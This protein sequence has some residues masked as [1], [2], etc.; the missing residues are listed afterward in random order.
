MQCWKLSPNYN[1]TRWPCHLQDTAWHCVFTRRGQ[2]QHRNKNEVLSYNMGAY[3]H[4]AVT[5]KTSFVVR[6]TSA[7][8]G[9]SNFVLLCPPPILLARLSKSGA[10]SRRGPTPYT[11]YIFAW[12]IG[13]SFILPARC[14]PRRCCRLH[15]VHPS[16]VGIAR[17]G[18]RSQNSTT[19]KPMRRAQRPNDGPW[20]FRLLS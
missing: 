18:S 12:D 15:L 20:H 13:D 3:Q 11:L 16:L 1:R 4:R 8:S 9:L 2:K 5:Y 14:Q 6:F 17:T 19:S 7:S 10:S